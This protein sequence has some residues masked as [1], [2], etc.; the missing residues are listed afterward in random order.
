MQ[1]TWWP[2]SLSSL[3]PSS[4]PS[5]LLP[6]VTLSHCAFVTIVQSTW[7]DIFLYLPTRICLSIHIYFI[8]QKCVESPSNH[9]LIFSDS[10]QSPSSLKPFLYP[11]H[12]WWNPQPTS[13]LCALFIFLSWHLGCLTLSTYLCPPLDFKLFE[14]RVHSFS[15]FVFLRV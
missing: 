15:I 6:A 5:C 9:L 4:I 1:G 8:H 3:S 13:A 10:A 7:S 12:Q 2:F 11:S 14:G